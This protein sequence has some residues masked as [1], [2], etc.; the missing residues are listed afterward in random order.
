MES[1]PWKIMWREISHDKT[2]LFALVIF[3]T[4]VAAIYIWAPFVD[5]GIIMRVDR[6]MILNR[7]RPPCP[8]FPLGTDE[9][10]RNMLHM[11]ILASRNSLNIAFIV[12]LAGTV[13]GIAI[14][15]FAGFYG[16]HV[17][18]ALMR[19]MDFY[20]MIPVIMLVILFVR[21]LA[22]VNA[23]TFSL[24]LI[25]LMGWQG[26]ARLIRTM[27]LRQ[28]IMD[29]VSASKTMG[30]PN[31]VIIFREVLP[32]LISIITSNFTITLAS[33]VGIETGLS[34]LGLGMPFN[35]P[36]LGIL[37]A[38]ARN[39]YD[40]QN[41]LWLWLPAALLIVILMLCINFVGQ[42]LNRAADAKKRLV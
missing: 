37:V 42:A 16:G 13:I 34:F 24:L 10:G 27:T 39:P 17:D 4:L 2:A 7:L 28:G 22:P 1:S 5:S 11:L 6:Q 31:I 21:M 26:T 3:V 20:A 8:D 9:A 23:I 33:F 14:G 40:M 41:R 35:V 19:F 30:T 32:N 29:Y 12:A 18:N 36:S 25:G 38:N 15:L